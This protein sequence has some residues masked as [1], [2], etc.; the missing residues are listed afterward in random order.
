MMIIINSTTTTTSSC[1]S[2]PS[3][4]S[5]DHLEHGIQASTD[6]GTHS[7]LQLGP[8]LVHLDERLLD[9]Q[10]YL[11]EGFRHLNSFYVRVIDI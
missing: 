5:S 11:S 2:S 7:L 10:Q 6:E 4:S 9:I 3:S 1:Y 8:E